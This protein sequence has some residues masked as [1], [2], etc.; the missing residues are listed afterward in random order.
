[1][2]MFFYWN[3]MR[4]MKLMFAMAFGLSNNV[5]EHNVLRFSLN[6]NEGSFRVHTRQQE[7]MARKAYII[8]IYNCFIWHLTAHKW[9]KWKRV[10]LICPCHKIYKVEAA[11]LK[12]CNYTWKIMILANM[13]NLGQFRENWYFVNNCLIKVRI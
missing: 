1:M 5:S 8:Y 13:W 10:F 6:L 9:Q 12:S 2:N 3:K 7:N 4:G 11:G